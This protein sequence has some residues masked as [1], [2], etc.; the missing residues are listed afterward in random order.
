MPSLLTPRFRIT[1]KN[2]AGEQRLRSALS[3]IGGGYVT[4]GVHDGAGRYTNG[5]RVE[6]VAAWM[7][8]GTM[9]IPERSFIRSAINE[10]LPRIN[11]WRTELLGK[12]VAGKTTVERALGALGMRVQILVQNQIKSGLLPENSASVQALKRRL[13][14]PQTT[15]I[16]TGLLLRSVAYKVHG[17]GGEESAGSGAGGEE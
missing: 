3:K 10:D 12:L 9:H 5:A 7:E 13:G 14:L 15:L 16:F 1:A 4:V 8:F 17:G 6:Q 2:K 11:K